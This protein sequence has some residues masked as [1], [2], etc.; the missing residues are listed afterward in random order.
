MN[1]L[2]CP[3]PILKTPRG[4]LATQGGLNQIKS[5]LLV[6]LMTNP[7]ERVMLPEFGTPLRTLMFEPNDA[8]IIQ[9]ARQIIIDSVSRWEP[10]I[11]VSDISVSLLPSSQMVT[12]DDAE[13]ASHVLFVS[14]SFYDPNL[15]NQV[16]ELKLQLP[17]GN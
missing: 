7:G 16:Q 9:Q 12:G 17:L 4:L 1:F 2:G 14:I 8:V 10:R 13:S 6:L 5:D 11:T 3:Y 15:I